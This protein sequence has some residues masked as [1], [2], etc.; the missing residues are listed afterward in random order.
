MS[1][2][3][4]GE[5][6]EGAGPGAFRHGC[7]RSGRCCRVTGGIRFLGPGEAAALAAALGLAPEAFA[8]RYVTGRVHPDTGALGEAL[9]DRPDGACVLLEGDRTCRAY[10]ARPARCRTFPAWPELLADPAAFARVRDLCPGI[11]VLPAGAGEP[12][13]DGGDGAGGELGV[14]SGRASGGGP[15]SAPP[16]PADAA[17]DP[18][19][20]P[21]VEGPSRPVTFRLRFDPG[22]AR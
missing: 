6:V 13:G 1:A 10:A 9:R 22:P 12:G 8:A 20:T 17:P 4:G 14:A 11:E 2:G 15:A 21:G 7:L 18:A 5:P 3:D 16:G 19:P